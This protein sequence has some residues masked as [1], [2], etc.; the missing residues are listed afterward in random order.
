MAEYFMGVRFTQLLCTAISE[1][2]HFMISQ[3]S[4][5]THLRY[6]MIFN[7]CFAVRL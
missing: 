5:V 1:H 3:G 2:K 7:Q 6:D 4:V